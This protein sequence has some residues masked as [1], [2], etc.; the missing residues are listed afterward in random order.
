MRNRLK[1]VFLKFDTPSFFLII[2]LCLIIIIDITWCE[3]GD[4]NKTQN[5]VIKSSREKIT[6]EIKTIFDNQIFYNVFVG[7]RIEKLNGEII[8]DI[9]GHKNFIPASN[10]KIYTTA[11]AADLLG[12]DFQY[13]T[14]LLALGEISKGKLNGNLL[15]IGSGDPSLGSWHIPEGN[16]SS[17]LFHSW[18]EKIKARGINEITGDI[19]GDGRVF[20]NEYYCGDWDFE[21]LP[22]WYA[23][24]TSG[25]VVEE[26]C[27]RFIT[28]PGKNVG[29]K[30]LIKLIPD[31]KYVTVVNNTETVAS[32]GQRTADIVFRGTDQNIVHFAGTIPIDEQPFQQRGS[33]WDGVLYTVFLFKEALEKEGIKIKGNAINI[34]SLKDLSAIDNCPSNKQILI[35]LHK[36]SPLSELIKIVNK[37]SHNFFADQILRTIGSKIKNDGSYKGGSNA[38]REWLKKIGVPQTEAFLMFDGSGLARRNSI[39]PQQTCSLLR[40]VYNKESVRKAFY[41]SL[42]IAGVNGDLSY[43]MKESPLK[44]N[45]RAKTGLIGQVRSFSGYVQDADGEMLVFGFMINQMFIDY[46]EVD[47]FIDLA[48]VLLGNYSEKSK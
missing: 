38:V 28:A 26:N 18:A 1:N 29:D 17:I 44:G 14:Q 31:T 47:K 20:T 9:N 36:S 16:D 43:R 32:G 2:F 19:I 7:I 48:C 8:C 13:E 23:A 39:Q 21:D 4:N 34:R 10:M 12:P 41:D 42:A 40:Y 5:D 46:T 33:V 30:A 11:S 27:F 37:Q 22:Y 15:I 25:L 45:L 6:S 24:G 35:D 3:S